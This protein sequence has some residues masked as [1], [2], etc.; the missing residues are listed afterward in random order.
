M[1]H[2]V[3]VGHDGSGK[4][5]LLDALLTSRF[6]FH[7]GAP[8]DGVV[9]AVV[10]VVCDQHALA[11][12]AWLLADAHANAAAAAYP[13]A[14]KI[15]VHTKMDFLEGWVMPRELSNLPPDF[16]A[17]EEAQSAQ[18]A[19]VRWNLLH[20]P[21]ARFAATFAVSTKTSDGLDELR[22]YIAAC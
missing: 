15:L 4:A 8:P 3:I 20:Q 6:T 17:D 21:D 9:P 12:D 14:T 2:I 18:L 13:L 19:E 5:K 11:P 1:R 22:D 10:I 16:F 7:K